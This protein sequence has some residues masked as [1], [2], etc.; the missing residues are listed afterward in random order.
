MDGQFVQRPQRP[1]VVAAYRELTSASIQLALVSWEREDAELAREAVKCLEAATEEFNAVRAL[2]GEPKGEQ[3]RGS[4]ETFPQEEYPTM[5][6]THVLFLA[7]PGT[8]QCDDIRQLLA[9]VHHEYRHV[10][11]REVDPDAPEGHSLSQEYGVSSLPALIVNDRL[12]LVGD[13]SEREVRHEIE[14]ARQ[15]N[16]H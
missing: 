12:R 4:G 2:I 10:D 5:S 9:R 15:N 16:R 6:T 7:N 8:G 11:V 14:K 3:R 1:D 13:I